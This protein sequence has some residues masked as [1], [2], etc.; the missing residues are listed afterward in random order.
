MIFA[1][2]ISHALYAI[3][4]LSYNGYFFYFDK[5][6]FVNPSFNFQLNDC[7]I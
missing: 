2:Y 3:R 5:D 6:Y 7:F 1:F 4:I